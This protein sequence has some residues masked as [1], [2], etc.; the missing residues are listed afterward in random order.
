MASQKVCSLEEVIVSCFMS[1][2]EKRDDEI[3]SEDS[4]PFYETSD[5]DFTRFIKN[6]EDD[7]VLLFSQQHLQL[8]LKLKI[9]LSE[10]FLFS[11]CFKCYYFDILSFV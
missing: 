7:S 1:D 2:N 9:I 10:R 3:T 8:I 5:K 6:S 11:N 4:T